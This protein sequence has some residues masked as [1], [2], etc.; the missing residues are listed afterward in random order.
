V[1][2]KAPGETLTYSDMFSLIYSTYKN[3]L[4][5]A[6]ALFHLDTLF[7]LAFSVIL[8]HLFE[9]VTAEN[10]KLAYIYVGILTIIWY[11][12][13]TFKQLGLVTSCI[14]ASQI[15]SGMAMLLYGKISKMTSFVLN[16]SEFGKITN[17]IAND[18]TVIEQRTPVLLNAMTAP[19]LLVGITIIL[20]IRIG[21]PALVGIALI[22]IVIPFSRKISEINAAILKQVNA[23]K[24]V[25][26]QLTAE[27]IDGIKYVKFNGWERAFQQL[28]RKSRDVE[29]SEFK[30]LAFGRA[31]ERALGNTISFIAALVMIIVAAYTTGLN[32]PKLFSVHEM[33]GL[34]KATV[35]CMVLGIA[36]YYETTIVF[37]RFSV[38]FN[39][40]E[41]AMI[42][43]ELEGANDAPAETDDR[44]NSIEQLNEPVMKQKIMSKEID[45]IEE[46][47][48][49]KGTIRFTGFNGFWKKDSSIPTLKN[50][51]YVFEGPGLYGITGKMG[52]GK[53]GLFG[54]I[55]GEL[56]YYSGRLQ[57]SGKIAYLAQEP[58]VF[59]DT[60]RNNIIF[61]RG[62]DKDA[63][64]RAIKMSCL[65]D[66]LKDFPE[67]ELTKLGDRGATLSRGEKARIALARTVYGD[68]DIYLFDDPISAL[69]SKVAKS[70]FN[71]CIKALGR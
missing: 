25:R 54:A 48:I 15:K 62:Y 46:G 8:L 45:E 52:S 1:D 6:V 20:C 16:A 23:F 56:P 10:R 38:I 27:M 61:G 18:L 21:W 55:L 41:I 29:L 44:L 71:R 26:V 11:I 58:V 65:A 64:Q 33:A 14:L 60:I 63:Y 2:A 19:M 13:H 7:R 53:S 43:K 59:S 34:L 12:S 32:V 9:E 4:I 17:L 42:Q 22:I 24:D 3:E 35:L 68:S 57:H 51:N 37:T 66:D 40:P 28:I 50:I 67:G 36:L 47:A 49:K 69:D 31:I 30:Y 39:I 70:I 5:T